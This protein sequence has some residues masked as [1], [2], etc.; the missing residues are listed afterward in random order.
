[1]LKFNLK[2]TNE[3]NFF[4]IDTASVARQ[5][6]ND[7]HSP[8]NNL[9]RKAITQSSASRHQTKSDVMEGHKNEV[10]VQCSPIVSQGDINFAQKTTDRA[11]SPNASVIIECDD[12]I[13]S[14]P[15]VSSANLRKSISSILGKEMSA[16]ELAKQSAF[17]HPL[18]RSRASMGQTDD[19]SLGATSLD[20]KGMPKK[21]PMVQIRVGYQLPHT[22]K[23][24]YVISAQC[25]LSCVVT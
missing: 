20:S 12:D 9:N 16:E 25:L 3:A 18:L 11:M 23:V 15:S 7:I 22:R 6:G 10:T 8:Q 1:M 4:K 5:N 14:L 24:S 21:N 2:F 19:K 13:N 17:F